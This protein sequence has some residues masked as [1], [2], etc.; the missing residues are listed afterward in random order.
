MTANNYLEPLRGMSPI[1]TVFQGN[2]DH[3]DAVAMKNFCSFSNPT[4]DIAPQI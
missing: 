4:A 2:S 3:E 1:S